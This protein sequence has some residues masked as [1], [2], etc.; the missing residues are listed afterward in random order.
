LPKK[1][2]WFPAKNSLPFMKKKFA[3]RTLKDLKKWKGILWESFE[4]KKSKRFCFCITSQLAFSKKDQILFSLTKFPLPWQS[5]MWVPSK[6][7]WALLGLLPW[8]LFSSSTRLHFQ[9]NYFVNSSKKPHFQP[10]NYFL[11]SFCNSWSS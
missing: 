8:P 7:C 9:S 6:N 5:E 3:R 10:K 4:A 2:K 11:I 1:N